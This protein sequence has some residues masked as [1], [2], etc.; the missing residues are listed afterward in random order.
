MPPQDAGN[1]SVERGNLPLS[2]EAR[3]VQ[4]TFRI[5]THRIDSLKERAVHPL[6]R[7]EYRVLRALREVSFE[8]HRGEFFGIVGR[9]GSGKST[10]LKILAGIYQ[11]DAGAIRMA[12]RV[13]PFIELGVG[14]N[15]ELTAREN[16][17]LNG[18]MMGLSR[19][20]AR[21]AAGRRARLRGAPRVRRPEAEELFL[22]NARAPRVL[23]DDPGR[24]RHPADRRGAGRRGCGLPAEVRGRLRR[25][26]KWEPHGRARHPRHDLS[27]AV[28][29]PGDAARRRTAPLHR[30]PRGGGPPVPADELRQA[31]CHRRWRQGDR[32]HDGLP[33]ARDRYLARERAWRA[34]R[35]RGA[36]RADPAENGRRGPPGPE[37]PGI[38]AAGEE[39]RRRHLRGEHCRG[40]RAR[41]GS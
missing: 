23:V 14:F 21:A 9:N 24:G 16:V 34:D 4:K 13:A 27:A 8:V 20:E 19:R 17:A 12:G 25:H 22:G 26:A 35:E 3:G 41:K 29:R 2:I 11:A 40:P 1:R 6:A 30:G 36:R 32:D 5:P 15:N 31:T 18:V 38:H 33:D 10:L 37:Q 7:P 39:R 28:L